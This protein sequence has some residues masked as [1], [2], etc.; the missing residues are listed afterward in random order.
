MIT[1][2][3]PQRR[4]R[5][6][7]PARPTARLATGGEHQAALAHRLTARDRWLARMLYEHRV[8]TTHQIAEI[9]F[10]S[11][12]STNHRLLDL[13]R[14]R[15]VDRFQPFTTTGTQPMHYVLDVAG[16]TALAFEDGLDP[17][18]IA[19]RHDRAV[20]VAHSLRLAHDIACNGIFTCLINASR[21]P[22]APG[23][24]SAWW[25]AARCAR[26]FGDIVRPD[27]YGRWRTTVDSEIEW[28]LEFDFGTESPRILAAKLAGYQHLAE[29]TGINT[30]MLIW[31]PSTRRETTIRRTLA[32]ELASL[33]PRLTPIATSSADLPIDDPHPFA[34]NVSGPRWLPLTPAAD[35]P[36]DRLD[37]T[38]LGRLWPTT[39]RQLEPASSSTMPESEP[40]EL[41]LPHALPPSHPRR[42][43]EGD[44]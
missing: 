9:A 21:Q 34:A 10:P 2:P 20:G 40:T 39:P 37:F 24:L 12:R 16:A 23:T 8:L 35:R 43:H 30:P 33:G 19:Y 41:A 3:T 4:L 5:G 36:R 18:Q 26:H 14:W 44:Q 42:R 22:G 7:L 27:G 28:F 25:S 11:I 29:K 6:H 15:V 13:Y 1:N 32:A 38:A 31:F 17:S